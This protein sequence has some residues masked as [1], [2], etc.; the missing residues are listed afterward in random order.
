M[1]NLRNLESITIMLLFC[2]GNDY[3]HWM[4]SDNRQ[5]LH[6]AMDDRKGKTAHAKYNNFAVGS[7]KDKYRL[8]S[9]GNFTGDAG[10]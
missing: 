3:L 2:T 1:H 8:H 9:I 10:Q 6:I 7:E 5:C 4:T